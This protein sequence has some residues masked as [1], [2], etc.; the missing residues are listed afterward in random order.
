[1]EQGRIAICHA[2]GTDGPCAAEYFPYGIYSVPEIS[3]VGVTEDEVRE[4]GSPTNAASPAFA[5][6]RAATSWG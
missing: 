3:T 1:M 2:F 6:P 4:R 5:K